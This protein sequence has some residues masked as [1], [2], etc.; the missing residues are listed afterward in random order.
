MKQQLGDEDYMK[1][2]II[3]NGVQIGEHGF[4]PEKIIEEIKERCVDY[5][6]NF[7]SLRPRGDAFPQEYFIKWANILQKTKFTLYITT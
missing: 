2:D 7:A 3:L 6:F 5:G 4:V 1:K